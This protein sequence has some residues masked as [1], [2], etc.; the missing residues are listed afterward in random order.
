MSAWLT[1]VVAPLA[2]GISHAVLGILRSELKLI[3][4]SYSAR[5]IRHALLG[6]L[7]SNSVCFGTGRAVDLTVGTIQSWPLLKTLLIPPLA[8]ST[9]NSVVV[10]VPPYEGICEASGVAAPRPRARRSHH[11]WHVRRGGFRRTHISAL[12]RRRVTVVATTLALL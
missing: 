7:R 5:N 12:A 10:W 2:L 8:C 6:V 4:A 1:R 3:K 9:Q 11:V